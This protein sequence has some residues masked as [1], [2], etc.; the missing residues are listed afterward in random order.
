[1]NA[2]RAVVAISL[3]GV[4]A[5]AHALPSFHEVRRNWQPS[6]TTVV[7]RHGEFLQRLRTDPTVRRGQWVVL[8]DV[9]PALRTA[10]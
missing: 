2:L 4:A 10:M 8:Q 5:V 1:M 6:D 3:L 9:S 7:D